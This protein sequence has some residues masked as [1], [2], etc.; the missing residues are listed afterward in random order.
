MTAYK[1]LEEALEGDVR[2]DYCINCTK[3][4]PEINPTTQL[5]APAIKSGKIGAW[6]LI[7]VSRSPEAKRH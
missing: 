2:Y 5:L 3:Y 6:V 1:T 7:Q 4:L